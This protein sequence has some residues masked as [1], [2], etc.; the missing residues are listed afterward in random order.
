MALSYF[1]LSLSEAKSMGVWRKKSTNH[2]PRKEK[3]KPFLYL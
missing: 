1:A 3:F 2:F